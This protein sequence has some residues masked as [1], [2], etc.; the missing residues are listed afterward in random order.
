M[1]LIDCES[2]L[3]RR[4]RCRA[5]GRCRGGR[6]ATVSATPGRSDS[7][8]PSSRS[9]SRL[10]RGRSS[11]PCVARI[12]RLRCR[13]R[14]RLDRRLVRLARRRRVACGAAASARCDPT[15]SAVGDRRSCRCRRRRLGRLRTGSRLLVDVLSPLSLSVC[16]TR[17]SD[18]VGH[19]IR[20][21]AAVDGR[22]PVR[23]ARASSSRPA[24]SSSA[25]STRSLIA[26]PCTRA[27]AVARRRPRTPS[28]SPARS[29]RVPR[30][31][32]IT[33]HPSSA[34]RTSGHRRGRG[35]SASRRSG[36]RGRREGLHGVLHD[37]ARVGCG[38]RFDVGAVGVLRRRSWTGSA[39]TDGASDER[40]QECRHDC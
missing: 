37:P 36:R 27:S 15:A 2:W 8:L 20:D 30:T 10:R 17:P 26:W 34:P 35:P 28:N 19:G 38:H 12:R 3:G 7:A 22:E 39:N 32:F 31:G 29:L 1:R 40:Q 33:M 25:T 18:A 9:T 4:R 11:D 23:V 24:C 14:L 6:S 13:R 16:V 5:R 21:A